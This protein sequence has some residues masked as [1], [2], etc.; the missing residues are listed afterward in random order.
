MRYPSIAELLD[1]TKDELWLKFIE[2]DLPEYMW[3]PLEGYF[4]HNLPPGRFLYAIINDLSFEEVIQ[5]ADA[6][7]RE[8][9]RQWVEFSFFLHYKK[10]LADQL[11]N[12][13]R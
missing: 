5:H 1:I 10:R 6:R 9:L 7:N 11:R 2:L 8:C 3:Q 12:L 4:F 13:Y